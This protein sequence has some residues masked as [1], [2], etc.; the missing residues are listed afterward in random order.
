[1]A[2]KKESDSQIVLYRTEDG[3]TQVE[4]NLQRETVW[5]DTH[6]MA[7]LFDRDRTVILRHLSNVY[8][9]NELDKQSTCANFAQ[10]A[11]DGKIRSMDI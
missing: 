10:V 1:M 7:R 2:R 8:K 11:A 4:V 3:Q 5:L 6:Q 9:T